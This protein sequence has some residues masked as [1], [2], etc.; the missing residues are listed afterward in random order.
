M[1][2]Q[3]IFLGRRILHVLKKVNIL[4]GEVKCDID[5]G[6]SVKAKYKIDKVVGIIDKGVVKEVKTKR[7]DDD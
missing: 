6:D 5:S 4:L 2:E 1:T 7:R 3:D